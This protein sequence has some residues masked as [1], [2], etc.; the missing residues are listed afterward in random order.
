MADDNEILTEDGLDNEI[1]DALTTPED[2]IDTSDIGIEDEG[3]DLEAGAGG[4]DIDEPENDATTGGQSIDYSQQR[5]QRLAQAKDVHGQW[6]TAHSASKDAFEKAQ[7]ALKKVRA[8]VEVGEDETMDAEQSVMDARYNLNK[9]KDG[10]DSAATYMETESARPDIA[11]AA[12]AWLGANKRYGTDTAFTD[13]AKKAMAKLKDEGMDET[14]QN[15]YR[16]VDEQLRRTP[17]MGQNSRVAAAGGV[18]RTG[19]NRTPADADR[20]GLTPSESKFIKRI[21]L[22]PA[23]KSV[24][25]E[26][27][28]SKN[29]VRRMVRERSGS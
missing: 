20:N 24:R 1:D 19:K 9:M 6:V 23:S 8:D 11:P 3:G 13:A 10:L 7:A 18:T 22:D 15:F 4:G 14:H 29:Q 27:G 5:Q 25:A 17:K 16:K 2:R 21:G 12:Q 26:W 28:E